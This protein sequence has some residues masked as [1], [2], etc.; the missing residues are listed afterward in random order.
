MLRENR[1]IQGIKIREETL[2]LLFVD[3]IKCFLGGSEKYFN[4]VTLLIHWINSWTY[5]S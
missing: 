3:D 4:E 2:F 1:N 5:L